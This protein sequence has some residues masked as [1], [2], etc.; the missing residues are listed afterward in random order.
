MV[1]PEG[2][3]VPMPQQ[4]NAQ[5]APASDHPLRI[6]TAGWSL[7]RAQAPL[8][9]GGDSHLARYA[10]RLS[11]AEINS[12][13][14]RPH[15]PTTYVR[16][17]ATVPTSFR[18]SVKVPR[19]ITHERALVGIEGLMPRFLEEVA[20]LGDKL[21]PL[22]V[23]LPPSLSFNEGQVK[24]FFSLLRRHFTGQVVVEPRHPTWFTAQV[25]ELLIGF[26]VARVAADPACTPEAA[27]PGGW[28]GLVYYRLH[29]SPQIY[30]SAYGDERLGT[31]AATVFASSRRVETWCIFDNTTFGEA[32]SDAMWLQDHLTASRGWR[33][34]S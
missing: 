19:S 33:P 28:N 6:G 7:P 14:Y 5:S 21:G 18:F 17:A 31:I 1:L 25:A 29:G 12:S 2:D 34:V 22:L 26:R 20:G 16:W 3:E 32:L 30:R 8:F 23:Q 15:R 27:L 13:F 10:E 11:C 9:P 24:A 4:D